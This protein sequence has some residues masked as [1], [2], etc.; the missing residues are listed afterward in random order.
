MAQPAVGHRSDQLKKRLRRKLLPKTSHKAGRP[1][2]TL[3]HIGEAPAAPVGIRVMDYDPEHLEE[4]TIATLEECRAYRQSPTVSWIN[5]NGVHDLELLGKF[6]AEFDLHPL[7]MEDI[8]NTEHRPKFEDLDSYL[9]L[10]LKMLHFDESATGIG[11]EQV[12]LILAPGLVLSFQER[13]GDVFEGVR[14]RLRSN[15]GRLRKMGA[16]YLAYALLD[17]VVDS[18]FGILE[19]IG[20]QIEQLEDELVMQPAPETMGRIH[21][22]KREMILLRKAVWPLRELIGGLQ[23][24]ES[25]LIAES[26]AIFLRDVYDH[27]IQIIDTVETFRDV[28]SGLLDLYLSSISNRM[29]EVMKVLTVIATVFIPLSFIAGV[30]GMNFDFMPE[31]HWRWS[32]PLLWL[33]MLAVACGMYGYFRKKRWL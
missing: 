24:S 9:F 19:Q 5:L 27:T 16:D 32:Y 30:Y 1:P 17:A 3:V 28:L 25:P 12:S 10:V 2:G 20:D 4:T 8:V 29:N 6:G 14:E 21:H 13:E 22:F 18:Y 7:V 31:L 15:K 26:T 33:V 11:T 23:R